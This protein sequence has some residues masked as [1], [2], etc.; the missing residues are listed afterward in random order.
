MELG[1]RESASAPLPD[2]VGEYPRSQLCVNFARDGATHARELIYRFGP[3]VH[4]DLA[5]VAAYP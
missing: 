5:F 1:H 2:C 4:C 3:T